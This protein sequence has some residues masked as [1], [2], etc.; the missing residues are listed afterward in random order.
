MSQCLLPTSITKTEVTGTSE[1]FS[2]LSDPDWQ[3]PTIPEL[4]QSYLY[5]I[6]KTQV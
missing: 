3:P 2:G 1:Q 5:S 6:E 4:L